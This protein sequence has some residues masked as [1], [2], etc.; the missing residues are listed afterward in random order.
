MNICISVIVSS[1]VWIAA[2]V[3][4]IVHDT[5][6]IESEVADGQLIEPVIVIPDVDIIIHKH[7]VGVA[8]E[9]H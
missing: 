2:F 6:D 1:I 7:D 5:V 3:W 9:K 8:S 4:F